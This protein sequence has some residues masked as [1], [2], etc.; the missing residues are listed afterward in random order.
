VVPNT[1][2]ATK[3][4]SQLERM[5]GLI[6]PKEKVQESFDIIRSTIVKFGAF[7][8]AFNGGKD[9]LCLL[10]MVET[11]W[12]M[13]ERK[14]KIKLIF[15][16]VKDEFP[17]VEQYVAKILQEKEK[18]EVTIFDDSHSMF[19]DCRKLVAEGMKAVFLGTRNCDVNKPEEKNKH[20]LRMWNM[21]AIRI[22]PLMKFTTN[23]IGAYLEHHGCFY[24][25][26]YRNGFTSLGTQEATI[27]NPYCYS[28]ELKTYLPF[29]TLPCDSLERGSRAFKSKTVKDTSRVCV[30]GREA[31]YLELAKEQLLAK[32]YKEVIFAT[33]SEDKNDL[34][35][36]YA[37]VWRIGH[38]EFR[39][40]AAKTHQRN[41]VPFLYRRDLH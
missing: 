16:K 11:V 21:D 37:Y 14:D 30:Q 8:L 7:P 12:E 31:K 3:K 33:F 19:A 18:Y 39:P 41:M 40:L 23:N 6:Y 38:E 2:I 13:M 1:T 4:P 35:K 26:V 29:W 15:W 34:L 24:P 32:G 10:H 25:A 27:A 20:I 36:T 17:E 28:F 5:E 9:S 22:M